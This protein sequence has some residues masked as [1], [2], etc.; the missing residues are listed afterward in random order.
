M[1]TIDKEIIHLLVQNAV[2]TATDLVPHLRLSVPAI[3]K[4]I[5][6]LK[7]TGVIQRF[8]IQTD[9]EKVGK[10]LIVYV[11]VTLE[12]FSNKKT[13]LNLVSHDQDIL[14]CYSISGEYDCILKICIK[15]IASLE[16]KLLDLKEHRGVLKSHTMFCLEDHKFSPFARPDLNDD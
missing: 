7:E 11:L 9:H 4:R 16:R 13:I 5:A 12:Q 15:D 10:P 3:N 6:K 8:T 2:I 1:D 14:E